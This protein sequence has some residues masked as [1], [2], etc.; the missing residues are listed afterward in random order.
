MGGVEIGALT[1]LVSSM[2]W[3]LKYQ[4]KRQ[5]ARED[6]QDKARIKREEKRDADQKEE[7]DYYR[8]LIKNDL[9]KNAILNSRSLNLQKDLIKDLE[10]HNGHTEKFSEKVVETL[11][12]ICGKLNGGSPS[13]IEA[14][15]KLNKDRRKKDI[16]VKVE[17]RA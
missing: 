14:K 4:T 9:Q 7:R 1:I 12:L 11:T 5:A 10:S 3:Y 2:V 17:R 13:M 15:K 8:D 16:S 6:I